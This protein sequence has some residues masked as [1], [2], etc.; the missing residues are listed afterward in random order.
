MEQLKFPSLLFNM[1]LLFPSDFKIVNS[2]YKNINNIC[3]STA[4]TFIYLKL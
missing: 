1:S 2:N 4:T 3:A